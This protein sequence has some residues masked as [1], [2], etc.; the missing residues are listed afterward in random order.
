METKIL[1]TGAGGFIA[2]KLVKYF[3]SIGIQSH[4][5]P[6]TKQQNIPGVYYWNPTNQEIDINCLDGVSTIIHLAGAGIADHRWT[7]AYKA[8]ILESRIRSTQLLLN[9]LKNTNHQVK[10]FI[11]TSAIGYY[12]SSF[13]L[14]QTE[15]NHP[16]NSFLARVCQEWE[17]QAN[18]FNSIGIKVSI[19]RVGLVLSREAGML[20]S[21]ELPAK[22]GFAAPFG[23]G[24]QM[25]SW[26][27][28]DDLIGI[29][30]HV[31]QN[32]LSG[33]FN[34]VAPY[35]VSNN[36]MLQSVSQILH[37][38]YWLP[39]IPKW[40]MKLLLG[41]IVDLLYANQHVSCEKILQSGYVFKHQQLKGALEDLYT[42]S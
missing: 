21:I 16:G 30:G 40:F 10:H 24:K 18:A 11:S 29:Y 25:Q 8:T 1:I 33:V 9:T 4:L 7:T 5:L 17:Q 36:Q 19:I 37:K 3:N 20:K 27:H 35:P 6:R 2:R 12:E 26:I 34:A 15:E 23:N 31:F 28:I 41:D 13:T 39:G 14:N 42:L 38:P 22:F 32:R